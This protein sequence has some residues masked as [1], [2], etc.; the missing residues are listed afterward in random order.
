VID[1]VRRADRGVSFGRAGRARA[2][3]LFS[4]EAAAHRY[5]VLY[6]EAINHF[7]DRQG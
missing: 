7:H 5:S 6:R 2:L 1:L 3:A 4:P